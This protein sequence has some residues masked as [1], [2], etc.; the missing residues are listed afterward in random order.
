MASTDRQHDLPRP[1]QKA[2]GSLRSKIRRYVIVEGFAL[3]IVWLG[4]SFWVGL[5]L[6][7]LPVTFGSNEMPKEARIVLLGI[8]ALVGLWII[9]RW[10]LR[11]AFVRLNDRSMAILIERKFGSF[12][13][14]LMTTVEH[15]ED[16]AHQALSGKQ[17]A[18]GSDLASD[19][20][21]EEMLTKTQQQALLEIQNIDLN[22]IFNPFPLWRNCILALLLM[23][24]IGAFAVADN[25]SFTI[26][27]NRLYRLADT[28]WPRKAKIELVGLEITRPRGPSDA[29]SGNT[30]IRQTVFFKNKTIKV[31]KGS[32]PRLLVQAYR[33][34]QVIPRDCKFVYQT[35]DGARGR[36]HLQRDGSSADEYQQYSL[37]RKPLNNILS[38]IDFD[39]IGYDHRLSG[40]HI[41]VVDTPTVIGATLDCT[42]PG[43]TGLENRTETLIPSLQLPVGTSFVLQGKTNKPIAQLYILNLRERTE[44]IR[45]IEN[46]S[47]TFSIEIESLE[48]DISLEI[49][50]LDADGI[51]SENPYRV[52]ISATPDNPPQADL[53]L[54]GIGTSITVNAQFPLTG[55]VSDDYQVDDYWLEFQ[56]NG[57]D[58]R[59][60][61]KQELSQ[62]NFETLFDPRAENY[63]AADLSFDPKGESFDP[64]AHPEFDLNEFYNPEKFNSQATA[65]TDNE[66]EID[67]KENKKIPL[68]VGDKLTLALKASDLHDLTGGAN[69]GSSNRF[70]FDVVSEEK[71]ISILDARELGIRRR[72]E[73]I[74]Q[75]TQQLR[76]EFVRILLV[77]KRLKLG[78]SS[79]EPSEAPKAAEGETQK[80]KQELGADLYQKALELQLLRIQRTSQASLKAQEEL[81][82]VSFGF[83]EIRLELINNRIDAVERKKRLEE[84]IIAPVSQ[85]AETMHPALR[86]TVSELS[87]QY[88]DQDLAVVLAQESID[89]TDE[90]L[91]AM[92]GVLEKMLDLETFNELVEQIRAILEDQD[93][94]RDDTDKRRKQQIFDLLK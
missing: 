83:E 20:S 10:V 81:V 62:L 12:H 19:V 40:Y 6:D 28:S 34:Y 90:I 46:P 2:L 66:S 13:D 25:E 18:A 78:A 42:M 54:A 9:T 44:E 39:L 87:R 14:S 36:A 5:A 11:R 35:A 70:Q 84:H 1:I 59:R 23:S 30:E 22:Q 72:F 4:I 64:A 93:K 21:H 37:Q 85:I 77:S 71:L 33:N 73:Q 8:I 88:N 57:T 76:D 3:A 80:T 79:Y 15:P 32:S 26:W 75:E 89:E 69:I 86:E 63:R 65:S 91:L 94:L 82:G 16:A 52:F 67:L 43:Y 55:R 29:E 56:V 53:K 58:T 31:A 92:Q 17:D 27:S 41:E 47:D 74:L 24:S 38:S 49:T 68:H 61:E 51:Y 60:F 50:L 7:Y 48:G 45:D